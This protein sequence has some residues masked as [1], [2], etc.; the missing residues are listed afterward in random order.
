ML[1][2]L[3]RLTE[4]SASELLVFFQLT[5]FAVAARLALTFLRLSRVTEF[6]ARGAN[7]RF[8]RSL[9]LFQNRYEITRLT[10]LADYAARATRPGGPCLVRSLLLFWLL[11]A[12]G[13]AAELLIGVSKEASALNSHAWIETQGNIIGD[14]TEM[15][16]RFATLLRL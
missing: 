8:L 9:P 13:E 2:K 5:A 7:N 12:R 6:V 16:G 3:R 4:L 11:K 15:A 10:R 1:R 14:S